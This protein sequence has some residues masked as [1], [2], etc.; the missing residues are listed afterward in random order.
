M[1]GKPELQLRVRT[2]GDWDRARDMLRRLSKGSQ[3]W[4]RIVGNEAQHAAD[5]V[6]KNLESRGKLAG[7]TWPKLKPLT[8]KRKKSKR[9]LFESGQLAKAITAQKQGSTWFVGVV[10]MEKHKGS[11]IS[12]RDLA[13]VHEYGATIV[14]EWTEKQRRAFFAL[15]RKYGDSRRATRRKT[16]PAAQAPARRDP[17]TGRFMRP[18]PMAK[19][20]MVVVIKI[21]ARPFIF[22]VLQKLYQGAQDTVERRILAQMKSALKLS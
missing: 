10:S 8:L 7:T 18:K 21:P 16:S 15:L 12:L 17:R 22:P 2:T 5:L 1:A 13:G 3:L 4:Q 14:Q 6:R 19:G 11:N 9:I 20:R